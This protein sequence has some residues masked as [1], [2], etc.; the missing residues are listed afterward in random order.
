MLLLIDVGNTKIKWRFDG[1]SGE[2]CVQ[3]LLH[4][5]NWIDVAK[6]IK[7]SSLDKVPLQHIYVAS[8]LGNKTKV[9]ISEISKQFN[10]PITHYMP[11]AK[12]GAFHGCYLEPEKLGVDRWLAVMEAWYRHG[13]CVVVDCGT[14]ITID[15]ASAGGHH[16]G[17]YIVPGINMHFY[18]LC[19]GTTQVKVENNKQARLALGEDTGSAV[20]NGV[21]QMVVAFIQESVKALQE[22]M[23]GAAVYL[24][25]GDA[26]VVAEHLSFAVKRDADLVLAGLARIA[27]ERA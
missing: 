4:A 3:A 13:A 15:A 22:K 5:T 9:F 8:V 25:G 1:V 27:S 23:P 10:V 19:A 21:L 7:A 12:E 2:G 26:D 18:A 20:R 6:K 24:V 14:A 11:A 17:G 16:L